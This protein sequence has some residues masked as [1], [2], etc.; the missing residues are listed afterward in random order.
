MAYSDVLEERITN[1]YNTLETRPEKEYI[2]SELT[3]IFDEAFKENISSTDFN[4][5]ILSGNIKH[6]YSFMNIKIS[7][8]Y[9]AHE[10]IIDA[11]NMSPV[12]KTM[13]DEVR[14]TFNNIYN[15][16]HTSGYDKVDLLDSFGDDDVT[17]EYIQG[18]SLTGELYY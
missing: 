11:T 13:L 1:F 3:S 16:L 10:V 14:D 15:V 6:K 18:G 7:T 5:Y 2:V 9:A 12:I 17:L 8:A 4:N